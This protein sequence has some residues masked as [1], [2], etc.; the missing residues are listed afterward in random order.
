MSNPR[1][2]YFFIKR[3]TRFFLHFHL[4]FP[5]IINT[6]NNGNMIL[7]FVKI[8]QNPINNS[9][10]LVP[11]IRIKFS[12][13]DILKPFNFLILL[14]K[15]NKPIG[16]TLKFNQTLPKFLDLLQLKI[17]LKSNQHLYQRIATQHLT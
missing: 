7:F 6:R 3:H 1:H 2:N 11:I 15:I 13:V 16:I 17:F 9:Y 14:N 12:I 4:L 5:S 10:Y 8:P